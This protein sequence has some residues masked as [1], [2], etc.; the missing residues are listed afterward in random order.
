MK[1][2]F[3]LSA[4]ALSVSVAAVAQEKTAQTDVNQYGQTVQATPVQAQVQDGILVFQNKDARYKMWFDVRVQADGA[5]F[6]GAPDYADKIG[7]GMSTT[8]IG[9]IS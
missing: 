8:L 1:R 9:I 5:V 6:F 2:L 3:L 7:S 4:L